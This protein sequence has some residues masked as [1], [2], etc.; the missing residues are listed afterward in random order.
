MRKVSSG[1]RKEVE[2]KRIAEEVAKGILVDKTIGTLCTV[3]K[4]VADNHLIEIGTTGMEAYPK[5][6]CLQ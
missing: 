6:C 5:H 1:G 3:R 2:R 4:T